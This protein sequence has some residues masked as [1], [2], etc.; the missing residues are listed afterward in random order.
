MAASWS[1]SALVTAIACGPLIASRARGP[2]FTPTGKPS[3]ISAAPN[4]AVASMSTWPSTAG[5]HANDPMPSDAHH[6]S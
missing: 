4:R 6:A 5:D 2:R 3:T 1:T